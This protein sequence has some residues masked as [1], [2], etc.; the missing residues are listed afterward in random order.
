MAILHLT[1]TLPALLP[2]YVTR[3]GCIGPACEDSCCSGWNVS[4]DKKTFNAYRQATEPTLKPLI[5]RTVKRQRSMANDIHYGRIDFDSTNDDC[6]LM[7]NKLCKVQATLGESYLSH[8]CFTYP[9]QSREFGGQ[10]EQSL[11]LSCPEAARQALLAPDA[12]DFVEGTITVR[13]DLVQKITSRRGMS[14]EL[15][16]EVRICCMRLMRTEGLALWQRLALLGLF[17]E[18]LTEAMQHGR[19]ADMPAVI[20]GIVSMLGQGQIVDVLDTIAA[21]FNAQAVVFSVLWVGKGL[22]DKSSSRHRINSM[23][24]TGL[25]VDLATG[26]ANDQVLAANYIR[27]LERLPAA[28]EAAPYLLEHYVLNEMFCDLFPFDSGSPYDSYLRLV[29]R[30][31]V[32]RLTL[33]GLCNNEALPDADLL[34]K[35]VQAHYRRFE[36]DPALAVRVDKALK[37]SG[38]TPLGKLY[39]LLRT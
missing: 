10:H 35:T 16:N 25:G 21:D 14:L 11:H 32:L 12:F 19:S 38:R 7:E 23:I 6:P 1:R 39:P 27:G 26:E 8:T 37:A 18:R 15:M 5:E 17:C 30:F 20:D 4:L 3:F 34:V 36:H 2:R 31:G 33:A 28:L 9:R 29:A 24:S 13:A 22:S